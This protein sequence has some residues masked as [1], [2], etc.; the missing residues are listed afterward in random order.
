MWPDDTDI[1]VVH[2]RAQDLPIMLEEGHQ[3]LAGLTDMASFEAL[4]PFAKELLAIILKRLPTNPTP[5]KA[6]ILEES[7]FY[8]A[9]VGSHVM[10]IV[11]CDSVAA[12][13]EL[14]GSGNHKIVGAWILKH[15][16]P[17]A[18][19]DGF[20]ET[21][22]TYSD[23]QPPQVITVHDDDP[24]QG[25]AA[26][27]TQASIAQRLVHVGQRLAAVVGIAQQYT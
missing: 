3:E 1:N 6:M 9:E 22:T 21:A 18:L 19:F 10:N 17:G 11:A 16:D 2:T 7:L 27:P 25:D 4:D 20:P 23:D 26:E 24:P 5:D 12:L 8:G 14:C 15:M 13:N